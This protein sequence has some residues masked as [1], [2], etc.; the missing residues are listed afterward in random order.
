MTFMDK[1]NTERRNS[2]S[3]L[4]TW[5]KY[6][7]RDFICLPTT[8][9]PVNMLAHMPDV[10]KRAC[11]SEFQSYEYVSP[12]YFPLSLV[13]EGGHKWAEVFCTC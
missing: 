8:G 12:V 7:R 3:L 1:S 10:G 5:H 4:Q 6:V 11:V 2:V 9:S 13:I